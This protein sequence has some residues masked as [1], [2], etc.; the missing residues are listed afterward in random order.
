VVLGIRTVG[1]IEGMPV[2]GYAQY[3]PLPV[4]LQGIFKDDSNEEFQ[5]SSSSSSSIAFNYPPILFPKTD[6]KR[7][8]GDWRNG[9]LGPPR[10]RRGVPRLEDTRK[11]NQAADKDEKQLNS[12]QFKQMSRQRALREEFD[13]KV[14]TKIKNSGVAGKE[15]LQQQQQSRKPTEENKDTRGDEDL[16]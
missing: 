13:R 10:F 12:M 3:L 8:S 4:P 6:S 14:S 1:S 9:V 11:N 5:S 2:R 15:K 7:Q 16:W